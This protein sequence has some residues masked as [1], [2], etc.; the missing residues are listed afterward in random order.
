MCNKDNKNPV[1]KINQ[2]LFDEIDYYLSL[3]K[4]GGAFLITGDWGSGKTYFVNK[5]IVTDPYLTLKNDFIMLSLFSIDSIEELEDKIKSK[6]FAIE[7]PKRAKANE[8][9]AESPIEVKSEVVTVLNLKLDVKTNRNFYNI[10]IS[11]KGKKSN[12][13][14]VIIFDDFERSP[15]F[16]SENKEGLASLFGYINELT[17]NKNIHVILIANEKSIVGDELYKN[18]KDKFI[19]DSFEFKAYPDRKSRDKVYEN[20]IKEF[21]TEFYDRFKEDITEYLPEIGSLNSSNSPDKTP[22]ENGFRFFKRTIDR[23]YR[24]I[25]F[26]LSENEKGKYK[27]IAETLEHDKSNDSSDKYK[28]KKINSTLYDRIFI[29][30]QS[31]ND[32]LHRYVIKKE[33][34]DEN[35]IAT[36]LYKLNEELINNAEHLRTLRIN[37]ILININ[38]NKLNEHY[39]IIRKAVVNGELTL[40]DT[41]ELIRRLSEYY[42]LQ[43]GGFEE[44]TNLTYM[45]NDGN[46]HNNLQKVVAKKLSSS[47]GHIVFIN[48]AH[49]LERLKSNLPFYYELNEEIKAGAIN[50]ANDNTSKLI[51]LL[52]KSI[53]DNNYCSLSTLFAEEKHY[54]FRNT[55]FTK[56]L[57]DNFIHLNPLQQFEESPNAI[58]DYIGNFINKDVELVSETIDSILKPLIDFSKRISDYAEGQTGNSFTKLRLYQTADKITKTI[59]HYSEVCKNTL[60]PESDFLIISYHSRLFHSIRP[61]Y[62]NEDMLRLHYSDVN[63]DLKLI[64]GII[65][66]YKVAFHDI[67]QRVNQKDSIEY[68]IT[69]TKPKFVI[70]VDCDRGDYDNAQMGDVIISDNV[71][72]I[73][74]NEDKEILTN[75]YSLDEQPIKAI[76]AVSNNWTEITGHNCI[77][78]TEVSIALGSKK[79]EE[80]RVILVEKQIQNM[81]LPESEW[82]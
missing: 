45:L 27:E 6:I 41:V 3:D 74:E 76:K 54:N 37:L 24:L 75:E 7:S 48:E 21:K 17:E 70:L 18:Y 62:A 1:E 55:E 10:E 80:I 72:K 57:F 61:I 71:V 82:I 43:Q 38:D 4:P 50:A 26:I 52:K 79:I 28:D 12:K 25:N 81:A 11:E 67:S 49:L 8:W 53:E 14:R 78:G 9:I 47:N 46:F 44:F 30:S 32:Y 15:F 5:E 60:N 33:K 31:D 29:T 77:F 63:N 68:A 19:F 65:G 51:A 23:C 66:K 58:K 22:S 69:K 20:I 35:S 73:F 39:G 34:W 64:V 42:E 36:A 56:L 13:K 59:N 2:R 16:K 40:N